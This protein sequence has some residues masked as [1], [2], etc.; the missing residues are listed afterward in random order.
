MVA[1]CGN[2]CVKYFFWLINFLFFI[3][4]AVII[5]LSIWILTDQNF[6]STVSSTVKIDLSAVNFQNLYLFLYLTLGIGAALL[7]LGFFGCCGSCCESVCTMSLYFLLV[8]AL[9]GVEILGIVLYFV[10]KS[11][12]RET[13][14]NVWRNELVA[15]YS[16]QENIRNMLD[17]VQRNLN[18]CGAS[19]CS[20]YIPY[21]GFPLSC[22]CSTL[23]QPGCATVVYTLL[24]S[25]LV[26]VIVAAAVVLVVEVFAMIFSCVIISAVREKRNQTA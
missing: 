15:K 17:N 26:Y 25:N 2:K 22:Q 20:D 14:T 10:K 5:G 7:V 3:L 9:F 12:L 24:E 16:T 13:F 1:G 11:S 21:T 23:T 4:G 8:L 18:C 19:G 6:S